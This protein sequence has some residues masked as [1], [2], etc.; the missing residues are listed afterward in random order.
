MLSN[1][2]GFRIRVNSKDEPGDE[3]L[4]QVKRVLKV[5]EPKDVCDVFAAR[6]SLTKATGE[7]VESLNDWVIDWVSIRTDSMCHSKD[8]CSSSL[9][10]RTSC[11]WKWS[12]RKKV[13]KQRERLVAWGI[14]LS[15]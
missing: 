12:Y 4:D 5:Q 7:D 13:T 9:Y 10:S 3:L 11:S 2:A 15:C 14:A 6:V 1:G 8:S